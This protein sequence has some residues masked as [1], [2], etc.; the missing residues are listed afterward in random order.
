MLFNYIPYKLSAFA[1]RKIKDPQFVSSVQ[2]VAGLVLYP[3]YHLIMIILLVIFV[4]CIWGKLIMPLLLPVF[5]IFAY[6]Y[7]LSIKKLVARFRFYKQRKNAEISQAVEMRQI[8]F[9]KMDGI[10]MMKPKI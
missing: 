9:E 8:I 4:P 5:G 3:L 1:S 10:S 6:N 7:Y 2:F